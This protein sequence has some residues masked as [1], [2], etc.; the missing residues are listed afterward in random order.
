MHELGS[1]AAH[2]KLSASLSARD[3]ATTPT[4]ECFAATCITTVCT[5]E[6]AKLLPGEYYVTERRH[7][8]GDGAGFLRLGLHARPARWASAA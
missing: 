3:L 7:V 6:A 8:A 2:G 1:A 5:L 4:S